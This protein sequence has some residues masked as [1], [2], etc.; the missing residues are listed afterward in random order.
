MVRTE[1][2]DRLETAGPST[3]AS[4]AP[5]G[6]GIAAETLRRLAD[7]WQKHDLNN[8]GRADYATVEEL[9]SQLGF[10]CSSSYLQE[11]WRKFEQDGGT[12]DFP[13]FC[14]LWLFVTEGL[15]R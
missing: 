10:A 15:D 11:V 6:G 5:E 13:G 2:L 3:S 4:T 9:V 7:E 1:R 8:A 14:G 12:I